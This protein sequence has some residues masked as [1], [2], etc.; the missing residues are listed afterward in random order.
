LPN[1]ATDEQI[2][3]HIKDVNAMRGFTTLFFFTFLLFLAI[4]PVGQFVPFLLENKVTLIIFACVPI[5][6]ALATMW[7]KMATRIRQE[8]LNPQ[9]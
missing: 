9:R 1:L 4:T 8:Y 5:L 7:L 6:L 3:N 2:L